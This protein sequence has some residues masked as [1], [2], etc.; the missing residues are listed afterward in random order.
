MIRRRKGA[1]NEEQPLASL[2]KIDLGM[3][4]VRGMEMKQVY[5]AFERNR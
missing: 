2:E 3:S 5:E 1:V 4:R